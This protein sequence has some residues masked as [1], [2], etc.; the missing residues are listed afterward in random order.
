Y[1][2]SRRP[3]QYVKAYDTA[4]DILPITEK[5]YLNG[6]PEV[7]V[8]N[9]DV[10]E[11]DVEEERKVDYESRGP[12]QKVFN[13]RLL[14]S[15]A[16]PDWIGKYDRY[17]HCVDYK[18]KDGES[19]P[20]VLEDFESTYPDFNELYVTRRMEMMELLQEAKRKSVKRVR[21]EL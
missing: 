18:E 6:H 4:A 19:F 2:P 16:Q 11:V 5:T 17:Q 9:V 1:T 12:V 7:G 8:D 21:E 13:H 20:V 10:D 14:V 15:E 3:F